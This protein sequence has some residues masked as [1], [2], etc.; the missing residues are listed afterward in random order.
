MIRLFVSADLAAGG[1]VRL[2]EKQRH[3]VLHVMRLRVEESVLLLNGRDGLWRGVLTRLDKKAADVLLQEQIQEQTPLTGADLYMAVIKKEA[4]D[5]VIQKAVELGVRSIHPVLC[6]RSVVSKINRERLQQIAVE[7]AEQSERL[8][9][10]TVFQAV[11]LTQ[12]VSDVAGDT[13]LAF[14]NERGQNVGQLK[15]GQSVAFF[16]GPE[17]G[18]TPAEIQLMNAHPRA[19]SVHLGQTILRAET[20]A[21]AV[22]S[23]YAFDLF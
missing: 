3:Y 17:G 2:D 11:S 15:R 16:I 12:A 18:W 5:L 9:V 23:C 21:L 7:A 1:M 14:L 4:M 22:L 8:N 6:A 10:P 20:A 19:V 13:A